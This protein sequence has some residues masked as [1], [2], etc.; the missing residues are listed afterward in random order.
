MEMARGERERQTMVGRS[1]LDER[2]EGRGSDGMAGRE[3]GREW[4]RGR[5]V[6]HYTEWML[7]LEKQG[8]Q[9]KEAMMEVKYVV[10]TSA[11][12]M[13]ATKGCWESTLAKVY[14]SSTKDKKLK[15]VN[16]KLTLIKYVIMLWQD[17]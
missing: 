8:T 13:L 16:E 3:G 10:G 5:R 11:M 6:Q 17:L 1:V 7:E 14:L 12:L 9:I 2:R 4:V 15:F